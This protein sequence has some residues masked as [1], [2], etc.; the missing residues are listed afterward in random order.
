MEEGQQDTC[1][2][3]RAYHTGH[4]GTHGVLEEVVG[5]VVLEA[6][7]V[8]HTGGIGNGTDTGVTDKRV[9]FVAFLE[10]EVENLH[11]EDTAEG[12]DDEG[13]GTKA[14]DEH[15]TTGEERGGLGGGTNGDT[16][17]EGANVDDGVAGHLAET[18]G[19]TAF[20]QQVTKEEH[21]QQGQTARHDECA[22]EESD[23]GEGNLFELGDLARR[24]HT[25]GTLLGGGHESHDGRL[26]DGDESHVGVG[27]HSDGTH[28]VG[29]QL[30]RKEDG[31]G[32]V[33]TTDDADGTSLVGS[34]TQGQGAGVGGKNT[35]LCGGTD[36][37]EFGVGEQGGEVGH[38]TDAQEYQW[39]VPT[40]LH[41]V[42]KDMQH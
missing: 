42:I 2:D 37:E 11:E 23:N 25:D 8:G 38:G 1:G 31:C 39:R 20:L 34:E 4:I 6:Y 26:D 40:V 7:V 12:G 18:L 5:A 29:S 36:E 9:D 15:R 21:T 30:R 32:A 10:E 14:E 24:F 19:D 22:E 17:K 16:D 13:E 27:R 33:S 41:T 3:S 28:Q 35:R